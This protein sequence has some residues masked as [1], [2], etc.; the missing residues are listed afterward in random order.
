MGRDLSVR[1]AQGRIGGK[2]F[3]LTGAGVAGTPHLQERPRNAP[4]IEMNRQRL[5]TARGKAL[6]GIRDACLKAG[7]AVRR[8]D[9][10]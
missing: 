5:Q 2:A 1:L 10:E 8:S 4:P 6:S 3:P 9:R 7:A